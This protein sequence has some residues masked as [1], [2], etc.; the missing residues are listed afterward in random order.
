MV[1]TPLFVVD[2][3]ISL[4]IL[5]GLSD[6]RYQ[7]G[8]LS[9]AFTT[10]N[11]KAK[12]KEF[13][14]AKYKVGDSGIYQGKDISYPELFNEYI[15]MGVTHGIIKDYFRNPVKTLESSKEAWEYY[16]NAK[17]QGKFV[18]VGVAQ[19][20]TVEE[21]LKSYEDQKKI[22]YKMIAIGGLLSKIENHSRMVRVL[23]EDL[24]TSVL[25][26]M[27]E[28]YPFDS[29]FPLGVFSRSRIGVFK[30]LNVWA[31]DYKGWI[32]RYNIEQSHRKKDRFVQVQNYIR[33]EVLPLITKDRLLILSCSKRKKL[34]R[35]PSIEI[36]DGNA[37]RSLRRYLQQNDGLEVRII[38]AKHG[39]I[40]QA[41]EIENYDEKLTLKKAKLYRKRYAREISTLV[42][43]YRDV[44]ICGGKEYRVVTGENKCHYTVG[45]NGEQLHQ[46]KEW[47]YSDKGSK[48][49]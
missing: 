43:C 27:R 20:N 26:A 23:K 32:F 17:M 49:Y 28:K 1:L 38:S 46:L 42:S 19:G 15:K 30:Q 12:F 5:G 14:F 37:F 9:H 48:G 11:F 6:K 31:T 36:Y 40:N 34:G 41:F 29:I 33:N 2:R 45:K 8:I 21:Y 22:G 7:F 35:G 16:N 3:P 10:D 24:L 4:E 13:E 47:L 18:L 39:L 25:K 44:M